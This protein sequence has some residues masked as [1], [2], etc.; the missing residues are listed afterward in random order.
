MCVCELVVVN[1][2]S[3]A[4]A[5]GL[6]GG[7]L[8]LTR[9]ILDL[10]GAGSDTLA[11]ALYWGGLALLAVVLVGFGMSL[12]SKS[13]L[14]LRLFVGVAFPVLVWS[15]IEVFH[16]AGTEVGLDGVVGG[17]IALLSVVAL[18]RGGGRDREREHSRRHGRHHGAHAR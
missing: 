6:L 17:V 11:D 15:V 5:C 7:G 16:T 12:V 18:L 1:L 9:F 8:W 10:A 4:L 3:V 14:P 13:A 2:R